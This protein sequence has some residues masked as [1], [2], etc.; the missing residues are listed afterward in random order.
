MERFEKLLMYELW[1]NTVYDY[2][3]A[4]IVFV[5]LF[6][7]FKLFKIIVVGRIGKLA[8][9]TKNS[10]DDELIKAIEAISP[11]FY[12]VVALYFPLRMIVMNPTAEK[13]ITGV[14][15]VVVVYQVVK[16]L[17]TLIEYALMRFASKRDG[18]GVQAETTF[19]GIKLIVRIVLWIVAILLI[20]SNLGVNITSLIASLG[21]GGLAIAFAVQNVLSDLFSSFSIYFD[22]PFVVGDTIMI[23]TQTGKVK[24]I[25]LKTTRVITLE[26]DELVVSNS[27]LTSS[28]V[29]NFGKMKNRRVK[30]NIGVEYGTS[31]VKLKKIN[32]IVKKIVDKVEATEFDRCHFKD[33]GDSSLNFEIIYSVMSGDMN[34][35]MDRQQ[36]IN[37]TMAEAFEKEGIVMAFPTQTVHVRKD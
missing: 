13:V 23:G 26:G 37:F 35:Y 29:R 33:F 14:F 20:L 18:K 4:L 8:K 30:T 9:K 6:I 24:Y 3:F 32:E 31:L 28:Q 1:G 19:V 11:L 5:G 36:E 10:F 34:E 12:F 15:L 16:T 27:E 21:I 7:I 17:Q 22:K 25:G 2:G